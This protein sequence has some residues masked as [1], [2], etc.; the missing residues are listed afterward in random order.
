VTFPP[1]LKNV[2]A[3]PRNWTIFP[4]TRELAGRGVAEFGTLGQHL[5]G[6]HMLHIF[7]R[8]RDYSNGAR[9]GA[10]SATAGLHPNKR[11]VGDGGT[12]MWR[13]RREEEE[14][15]RRRR[16]WFRRLIFR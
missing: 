3:H 16:L 10:G 15:R 14:D 12:G 13:S 1:Q 4:L 6:L 5:E 9:T 8:S 11:T 7:R 2:K